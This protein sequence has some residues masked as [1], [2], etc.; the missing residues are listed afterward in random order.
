MFSD[1]RHRQELL[2]LHKLMDEAAE[3][4]PCQS[5]DPDAYYPES[6]AQ[7][8]VD[9]ELARMAIEGCKSCPIQLDCALYAIEFEELGIW[10]GMTPAERKTVR[11]AGL[12]SRRLAS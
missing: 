3:S 4:I 5:S 9:Q 10:G 6:G 1:T 2:K 8:S 11:L 7:G 12:K